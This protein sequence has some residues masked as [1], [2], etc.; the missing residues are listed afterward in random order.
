MYH[1][2]TAD[3]ALIT[4]EDG[5]S[6]YT[7]AVP[8]MHEY[9]KTGIL[10]PLIVCEDLTKLALDGGYIEALCFMRYREIPPSSPA[11]TSGNAYAAV[12]TQNGEVQRLDVYIEYR[13]GKIKRARFVDFRKLTGYAVED[14]ADKLGIPCD[15]GAQRI[16]IMRAY[17][18]RLDKYG[19][20][21][22]T[23]R[24]NALQQLADVYKN[25][26]KLDKDEEDFI[27][28][29]YKGGRI[30]CLSERGAEIE[31][32]D[33]YDLNGAYP[34]GLSTMPL[35][36]GKGE[37]F[38]GKPDKVP[39]RLYVYRFFAKFKVKS[40]QLPNYQAKRGPHGENEYV[41]ES[42][43]DEV[44]TM[45]E[46]ELESFLRRYDAEITYLDGY[47]YEAKTG[48]YKDYVDTW[49]RVKVGG[50]AVDR[51]IAKQMLNVPSGTLGTRSWLT[52]ISVHYE[53]GKRIVKSGGEYETAGGGRYVPAAAFL[54]SYIRA[55]IDAGID[56]V[57]DNGGAVT[58]CNTDSLHVR[59]LSPD[60][61]KALF[62][63]DQTQLG[64][65]KL[66]N[67][68]TKATYA[69]VGKYALKLADG[70]KIVL[71]GVPRESAASVTYDDVLNCREITATYAGKLVAVQI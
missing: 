63:V 56:A 5:K 14:I 60:Q 36:T 29:S 11:P 65:Y 62:P 48:L 19:L 45:T 33:V 7:Y 66:E 61:F 52:D 3:G 64:A 6:V 30:A 46:V 1:F 69:G 71:A 58:Y 26:P 13:K 15:I 32:V 28:E 50:D 4:G 47:S 31:N 34:W 43:G 38:I 20:K 16:N 17:K 51:M 2:V 25:F 18:R 37:F 27:R 39:G 21:K 23:V 57:R 40:G 59:G 12:I 42:D 10:N 55:Y 49:Q 22:L 67:H 24:N 44:L 41:L 9:V 35:P 8:N 68:A 70:E 54:T 53:D